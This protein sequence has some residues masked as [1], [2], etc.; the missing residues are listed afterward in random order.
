VIPKIK[1]TDFEGNTPSKMIVE[2][3][4]S[5][6]E[7]QTLDPDRHIENVEIVE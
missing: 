5:N 7:K 4:N 2:Y 6:G 3:V 1:M